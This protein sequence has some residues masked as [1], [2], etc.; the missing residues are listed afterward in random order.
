VS[1]QLAGELLLSEYP[2]ERERA[3]TARWLGWI[4]AHAGPDERWDWWTLPTWVPLAQLQ[5]ARGL[6][7]AVAWIVPTVIATIVTPWAAIYFGA[8]A[9]FAIQALVTVW[10]VPPR[11]P[12][13]L[14]PGEPHAIVPRWP[15][16]GEIFDFLRALIP[17]VMPFFFAGLVRRWLVPARGRPGASAA[18]TYRAD[19]LASFITAI[20]WLPAG[21]FFA[22]PLIFVAGLSRKLMAMLLIAL[23]VTAFFG[24]T[25]ATRYVWLKMTELALAAEWRQRID[26]V[27]LLEEAADR[28]V[29]RRAGTGY[30]FADE[31]LRERLDAFWAEELARH[32]A[33]QTRW[34][35]RTGVRSKIVAAFTPQA[36][37]AMSIPAGVGVGIFA[38]TALLMAVGSEG[39]FD[40]AAVVGLV[41]LA[42]LAGIASFRI[43]ALSLRGLTAGA[44]WTLA[45][46][47]AASRRGRL[48]ACAV[49]VGAAAAILAEFGAALGDAVVYALPAVF[50]VACGAWLWTLVRGR[51]RARPPGRLHTCL[52]GACSVILAATTAMSL[53]LLVHRALLTTEPA[54][55]LLFPPAVWGGLL[56]WRAMRASGRLAVRAAA[57]TTLSL[58]LGAELV[59]FLVWL[60]NLLDLPRP[61]V[62]VLRAVLSRIGSVAGL[63]WWVWTGLFMLLAALSLGF[64]LRPARLAKAES[65]FGRLRVVPATDAARRVLAGVHIGLMVIVLV[66]AAAPAPLVPVLQRQFKTVYSVAFQR[67]LQA[68]GELAAYQRIRA[69]FSSPAV[70]TVLTGL[71]LDIHDTS[72]PP[73]GDDDATATETELAQLLGQLQATTLA[74]KAGGSLQAAGDAA[75]AGAGL[76]G[77]VRDETDLASRVDEVDAEDQETDEADKRAEGF[78]DLAA[79]A[80][81]SSI[82]ITTISGNEV[83][84]IVRDYLQGLV[85]E[86]G[87]KDVFAAWAGRLAGTE[88]PPDAETAVVPDPQRLEQAASAALSRESTAT[89]ATDPVTDPILADDPA[90]SRALR[91]APL[92]AAVSLANQARFLQENSGP[93]AGCERP[94]NADENPAGPDDDGGNDEP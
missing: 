39:G 53:L 64:V 32:Q 55:G 58:V 25:Y 46:A 22:L 83:F 19:R 62:V 29:V 36:I 1:R 79:R 57:D 72:P 66:A 54:A 84:E 41:L 86:S 71:V 20:S 73:S 38:A 14:P 21:A 82:S 44:R 52:A 27:R 9:F 76:D 74:V 11:P 3:R 63:P 26:F 75:A 88:P 8:A 69:Q 23:G 77:P 40:A 5:V 70:N 90:Y 60:A 17:V 78:G 56:T 87:L 28:G 61:E 50:V 33:R 16:R 91:E 6:A 65:W 13:R 37:A 45:N 89:G 30:E 85:E 59:L 93:C 42:V 34:A 80:I 51:Q 68:A 2:D 67:K 92:A 81:A 24:L 15:R 12:S 35:A 4:A 7:A 31:P 49:L 18:S 43:L 10:I 48:A 47:P 94:Q